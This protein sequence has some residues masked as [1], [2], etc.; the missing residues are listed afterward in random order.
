MVVTLNLPK[1]ERKQVV[2]SRVELKDQ[3]AFL[4]FQKFEGEKIVEQRV[5]PVRTEFI[6]LIETYE[7]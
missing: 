7:A 5:V 1:K 6:E 2:V 3:F 4:Y